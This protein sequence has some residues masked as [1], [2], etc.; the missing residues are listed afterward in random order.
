MTWQ[1][2]TWEGERK[3]EIKKLLGKTIISWNEIRCRDI[4]RT[5]V[6]AAPFVF[7]SPPSSKLN[8]EQW[9]TVTS[10]QKERRDILLAPLE[11]ELHFVFADRALETEDDLLRRLCL[12]VE[13][14]LRLTTVTRLLTVVTPLSLCE[15]RIFALLVLSHLVRADSS[16]NSSISARVGEGLK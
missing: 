12:L 16:D 2:N 11:R 4:I 15:D 5:K 13:H 9:E 14:R 8:I 1:C 3:R 6:S 7:L 10:S